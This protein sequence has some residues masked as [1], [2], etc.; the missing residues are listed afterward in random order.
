LFDFVKGAVAI[1]DDAEDDMDYIKSKMQDDVRYP[2]GSF[3]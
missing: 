1:D 3:I 2:I